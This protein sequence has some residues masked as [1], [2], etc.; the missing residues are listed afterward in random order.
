M[1]GLL[2]ALSL[3]VGGERRFI[4]AEGARAANVPVERLVDRGAWPQPVVDGA[5]AL[6]VRF[7][8]V[9]ACR[10]GLDLLYHRR[11]RDTRDYFGEL[12]EEYPAAAVAPIADV[13]VWQ[14]MMLEN[15]DLRYDTQYR[16]SSALAREQLTAASRV[17]GNEG[18]EQFMLAGV[19]G[20]EAIHA[21]RLGRYLP[22][23]T[24]A[25]EALEH[26]GKVRSA[27]P[28]FPDLALAD[29]LYNYWRTVIARSSSLIPDFGDHRAEGIAQMEGVARHGVF[30]AP[31]ATLSM[32]FT[33]L[34]EKDYD[35]ALAAGEKN[36]QVYPDN[37]I[38]LLMMGLV[39]LKRQAFSDALV[40]FE[41]IVRRD[42]SSTRARYYR[43]VSLAKL[44]RYD[45]AR[46]ELERYVIADHL[47]VY[48]QAA[49][50]WRLGE[51]YRKLGREDDAVIQLRAGAKLGS[52]EAKAALRDG[53]R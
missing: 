32:L 37:T 39:Q 23:L 14:A 43:G 46:E 49:A 7:E 8:F 24:Q 28:T 10:K 27:A 31:P 36:R 20:L 38:N 42:P 35:K 3:G 9:D 12:A 45:E 1:I 16:A 18:W 11:Y 21:A 13:L 40:L 33:W 48:Q 6:K 22:A 4:P 5:R 19:V 34:E 17:V 51:V 44:E 29:G 41:E 15:F 30:L 53:G 52:D 47:Q 26:V 2:L 25:F 50:H